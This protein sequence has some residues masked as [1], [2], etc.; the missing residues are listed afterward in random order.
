MTLMTQAVDRTVIG[1]KQAADHDEISKVVQL[2]IDGAAKADVAKLTEAFHEDARMFGEAGRHE[3][4]RA[5]RRDVQ[6]AS[7]G[8]RQLHGTNCFGS[9]DW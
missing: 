4:R 1:S 6:A 5:H 2:Y 7:S 9:P 8:Y 3:A